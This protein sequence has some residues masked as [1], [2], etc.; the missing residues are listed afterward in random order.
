[1]NKLNKNFDREEVLRFISQSSSYG[2]LGAFIGAGFSKAVLND[3]FNDI[4]LSWGELLEQVATDL[5]INYDTIW[6]EGVGYPEIASEICEE[7]ARSKGI[8][9]K[10]ALS[11]IKSEIA[12]LTGWYPDKD[13]RAKYS[14]SLSSLNFSW[15][16]TTNYDLVIESL[17]TGVSVP[18]GPNDSLIAP[19][20]LI[21]VFHLHG[22]R[23]NPDEIIIAQ[24]D[25]VG[26]F[27][28]TEYRQI[29]LALM[30]KESTMLIL[31]YGLGDV[32]VLTA[33]DW[34][35][36]VFSGEQE[37]YPNEVIQVVRKKE[38][39]DKPYRDRNDV[40]IIEVSSLESFFA[41]F[42]ELR[43]DALKEE[44]KRKRN[45]RKLA[46][47]LDDPDESMIDKF[48]DDSTYRK[49]VLT[50]LSAFSNDLISGFVSFLNKCL[51][52]TWVRSIPDGAFQG[53]A[54]NLTIVLDILTTFT[55]KQ[56]PPALFE[57][58]AYSL[59]RVGYYVGRE[60]GKS[61]AAKDVWDARKNKLSVE[62]ISE[63][64][65]FAKQH[66]YSKITNLCSELKA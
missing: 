15:I 44:K 55:V 1:M 39:K 65:S 54:D 40:V 64:K 12:A 57:T 13:Q 18:L 28:P 23:T 66:G 20:G 48:I 37:S 45:L 4:A 60:Y 58:T 29:K 21:P 43:K 16:M 8:S 49:E 33:L 26:L 34:S 19:N 53:Y 56:M 2:N 41:E 31:G 36:N 24:E 5:G 59:E 32:N 35:K 17:L 61:F 30:I 46:K 50:V 9:Y 51:D 11:K 3:G 7:Y 62:M 52:E 38:P 22:I 6:K 27:R 47:E 10:K 25:Y 42:I 14:D 63:L